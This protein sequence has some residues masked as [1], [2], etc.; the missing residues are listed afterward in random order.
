MNLKRNQLVK[1][2]KANACI[3]TRATSY[4]RIEHVISVT[5]P[6]LYIVSWDDGSTTAVLHGQLE[7]IGE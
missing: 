4:G 7:L 2:S 3:Y 1:L 6:P 5:T